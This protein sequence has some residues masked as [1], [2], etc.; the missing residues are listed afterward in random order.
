MAKGEI[1]QNAAWCLCF[2]NNQYILNWKKRTHTCQSPHPIQLV[3]PC[4]VPLSYDVIY[5][6]DVFFFFTNATSVHVA[7]PNREWGGGWGGGGWAF[8]SKPRRIQPGSESL[9]LLRGLSP[10]WLSLV[11]SKTPFDISR[12]L[13]LESSVMTRSFICCT[14]V[15]ALIFIMLFL[16][17]FGLSSPSLMMILLHPATSSKA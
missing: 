16:A 12:F 9:Y 1:I 15:T 7:V 5:Y 2:F 10:T 3:R 11:S 6:L 13:F 4:Y 8:I 17:V 14:G